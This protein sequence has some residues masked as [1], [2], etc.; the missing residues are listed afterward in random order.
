[1]R[2]YLA[3][4]MSAGRSPSAR[5]PGKEFSGGTLSEFRAQVAKLANLSGD[6]RPLALR[7]VAKST[8]VK[9][10]VNYNG[11]LPSSAPLLWVRIDESVGHRLLA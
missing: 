5:R 10:V 3:V 1:V 6:H 8:A 4:W 7:Q 2:A 11:F 9:T